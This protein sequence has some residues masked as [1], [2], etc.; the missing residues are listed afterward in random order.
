MKIFL[1]KLPLLRL[2]PFFTQQTWELVYQD[3]VIWQHAKHHQL[4]IVSKDTDFSNR[5]ILFSLHLGLFTY[6]LII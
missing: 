2:Y 5:I 1:N 3:T 4:V 6:A